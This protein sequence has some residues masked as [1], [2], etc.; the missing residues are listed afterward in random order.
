MTEVVEAAL[1]RLYAD[2]GG[3][4]QG[5]AL[6]AV[7]SLA[8]RELGPR[9]DV[10]L[11]L[12]HDGGDPGRIGALAEQVWYPLWDAGV[13]LDHSVRTPGECVDVAAGELTAGIG[14][15]DLRVIAGDT[16][17]TALTRSRL[18]DSWRAGARRRL[19]ELIG[20]ITE[21][22][23]TFGDAAY[24]LEPDLK[25]ARGGFRDMVMLRALAATWL[26]DRPHDSVREPYALLLDVRDALHLS[27]GRC[28]D[29][30]L[31]GE[32]AEVADRLGLESTDVLHRSVS[33]AARR[34]GHAVD[35]TVREARQV[36][37]ERRIF[38]LRR[39]SR[40]PEY[41]RAPYGLVVHRGEVSLDRSASAADPL[42]GLR[43]GALAAR[44]GLVLSPVTAEH[45]ARQAPPLPEPWP[46]P[47]REVLLEMLSAGSALVPVWE[48][49]DL[50]GCIARWIPRWESIR[51]LPQHNPIHRHTV[52]RHS[53]QTAVEAQ[54]LLND[55]E[56]PDLLLLACLVHDIGKGLRDQGVTGVEHAAAGAPLARDIVSGMGLSDA[57]ADL[58]AVL[59]RE[60][61]TLAEL[62]TRRDHGD[63]STV[64]ALVAAVDGRAETLQLLRALTESDARAAGPSA[65]SPWRS[66]LINALAVRVLHELD[67]EAPPDDVVSDLGT[68][69]ARSVLADG[70]P[71][72]R[73]QRQPGG[74]EVIIACRDRQRLFAD[75]AG[76]LAAYRIPVRSA[77]VSTV[78]G[79]AVNTWRVD[80]EDPADLPDPA[81]LAG[82]LQR[83]ADQDH[84]VL[85]PVQRRE[86]RA[87]GQDR[88]P[89]VRLLDRASR[90]ATVIE[91]RVADRSG[92]LYAL[93]AALAGDG[94]SIRSAHVTTLAGQAVDTF[95]LTETDTRR[96]TPARDRQAV[97]CLERAAAGAPP[98]DRPVTPAGPEP[99]LR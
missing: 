70:R 91:V 59:V 29:R 27:S 49:L 6:A 87:A 14:L 41:E 24:L 25:E 3:P 43:A 90:S 98:P 84:R 35:L 64:E 12:L 51:A 58:V 55:V 11:V 69:L 88:R 50:N 71:R 66:Q 76:L 60:H 53:V 2:A 75:T 79:V 81:Y 77:L 9:S 57:D 63:P 30:L 85:A 94:F 82:E 7:G 65:W 74:L 31:A 95:Y 45:L 72:V 16:E 5:V 10:D 48:A 22:V 21:R 42:V 23:E 4:E 32:A 26:T 15:L 17:L 97:R 40:R 56:R 44:R 61:L 67:G 68:G 89:Q 28:L 99:R 47:A 96:P 1:G 19:E 73:I 36:V 18:L 62:A 39:P 33:L 78:D 13:R 38:G 54:R 8:R 20:S 52:D 83:L 86:A 46:E 92:L 80:A 93:G 34:I 37:P